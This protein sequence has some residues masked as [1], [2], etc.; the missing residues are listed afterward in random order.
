MNLVEAVRP[1]PQL[2][3]ASGWHQVN[4]LDGGFR[5]E[6]Q[7]GNNGLGYGF[8]PHH[9]VAGSFRPKCVP[10]RS[11]GRAGEGGDDANALGTEFLPESIGEA[12][13]TELGGVIGA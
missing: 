3:R 4:F 13:G 1:S 5:R 6:F 10:N 12:E 11:V 8:G 7:G 9:P 2:E